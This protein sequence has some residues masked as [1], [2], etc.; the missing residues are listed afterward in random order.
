MSQ[1]VRD[2]QDLQSKAKLVAIVV[3]NAMETFHSEHL[4]DAEMRELNPIIRNAIYTALHAAD[5]QS[6]DEN[7]KAWIA[8]QL[9]HIPPYWEE[10]E[11]LAAYRRSLITG[12]PAP[13]AER[14]G[15]PLW[16]EQCDAARQIRDEFGSSPALSYLVGGKFMG[17][18]AALERDPSLLPEVESFAAEIRTIL[19]PDELR[20][21]L[22]KGRARAG[23]GMPT[24]D[25]RY[26]PDQALFVA[27]MKRLL[28]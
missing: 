10:P 22:L 14:S 13:A 21:Y 4:S 15:S 20:A 24:D 19:R 28:L 26:Y 7:A 12:D 11:L 18:L 8:T 9:I 2:S 3:R 6:H 25:L 1:S 5:A 16:R 17:A 23:L 27:Q